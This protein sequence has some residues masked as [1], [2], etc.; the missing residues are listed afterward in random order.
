MLRIVGLLI[1]FVVCGAT[2]VWADDDGSFVNYEAIVNDLKAS[3][4][5]PLPHEEKTQWDD[6]AIQGGLGLAT[7]YVSFDS[8]ALGQN[9]S[10]LMKG[11]EAHVGMNLFSRNARAEATFRNFA[12]DGINNAVHAGMR[13]LEASVVFLPILQDKTLLRMGGGLSE[14]FL[15]IQSHVF[16]RWVQDSSTTPFYSILLGFEHKIAKDV[17]V[18][19][20]F[21]HHAS[22][23]SSSFNKSSWDASF[24]LNATF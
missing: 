15:D 22:L 3:A 17:S 18:G 6:V 5:Q 7:S 19:P 11:F 24:R 12:Q 21:A 2:N 23:D 13:E 1:L 16:G 14:R 4:D 8:P 20:D 10:G 9:A